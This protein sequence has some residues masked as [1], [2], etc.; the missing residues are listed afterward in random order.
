MYWLYDHRR[1]KQIPKS[2]IDPNN[3][4]RNG[5]ILSQKSYNL[6]R[7]LQLEYCFKTHHQE[8][9][10]CLLTREE[11]PILEY[12]VLL[13]Q[14]GD[15]IAIYNK[16]ALGQGSYGRVYCGI[17]LDTGRAVSV[18]LQ[19]MPI[20]HKILVQEAEKEYQN[21]I[22][23]K[24]LIDYYM[25]EDSGMYY[26]YLVQ[27]FAY[28]CDYDHYLYD[29]NGSKKSY[30]FEERFDL[31]LAS[32]KALLQLH[33][34]NFIHRDLS[35]K[36]LVWDAEKNSCTIIDVAKGRDLSYHSFLQANPEGTLKYIAPECTQLTDQ[37]KVIYTEKTDIYALGVIF[38][39]IFSKHDVDFNELSQISDF[40]TNKKTSGLPK[41]LKQAASDIFIDNPDNN[42]QKKINHLIKKMVQYDPEKRPTL[43][44]IIYELMTVKGALKKQKT[45]KSRNG[46]SCLLGCFR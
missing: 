22:E 12:P 2:V 10:A 21:L 46:Y 27:P 32:A 18:K 24:K 23:L 25:V 44:K 45:K 42:L 39:D 8:R 7:K 38:C 6:V 41:Y 15:A 20:D 1:P 43:P 34:K 28:G 16:K 35:L 14:T 31:A 30:S 13:G 9:M 19:V 36:N 3:E 37:G 4:G 33:G 11:Y 26:I 5:R 17:S 29:N 40:T